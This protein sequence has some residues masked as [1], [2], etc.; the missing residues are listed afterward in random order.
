M[1]GRSSGCPTARLPRLLLPRRPKRIPSNS[2][3]GTAATCSP[4]RRK[5][6]KTHKKASWRIL[7]VFVVK[8]RPAMY[9]EESI[10]GRCVAPFQSRD[11]LID[12]LKGDFND[13][14]RLSPGADKF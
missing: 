6:A 13:S 3:R 5:D 7:R 1:A 8:K 2:P 10:R 11:C 9:Y 12:T 4:L 14:R